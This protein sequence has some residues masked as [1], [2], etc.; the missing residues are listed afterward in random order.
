MGL[1]GLP[2]PTQPYS[3]LPYPTLPYPTLGFSFIRVIRVISCLYL[4]EYAHHGSDPNATS[5]EEQPRVLGDRDGQRT[6]ATIHLDSQ[7]PPGDLSL[8]E[9]GVFSFFCVCVHECLWSLIDWFV[10][11]FCK[12]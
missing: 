7:G 12:P 4:T 10:G 11:G 6:M 8:A 5:N 9:G 1:S 2:Y 3:T